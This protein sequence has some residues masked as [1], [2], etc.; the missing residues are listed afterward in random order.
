MQHKAEAIINF[1]SLVWQ[2]LPSRRA[3]QQIQFSF[4]LISLL[5]YIN[6]TVVCRWT[7][8]RFLV[9]LMWY[10]YGKLVRIY[11]PPFGQTPIKLSPF[12]LTQIIQDNFFSLDN[13]FSQDNFILPDNFSHKIIF[14]SLDNLFS[15]NIFSC[16]LPFSH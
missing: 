7:S 8:L 5:G 10:T 13:F 4:T 14:L 15:Q 1:W 2:Q 9:L 6:Q 12:G 11:P 16:R 3:L